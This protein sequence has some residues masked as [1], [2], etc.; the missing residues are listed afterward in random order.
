VKS[1]GDKMLGFRKE[2]RTDQGLSEA[3][4]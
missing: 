3:L 4:N 2:L 1:H